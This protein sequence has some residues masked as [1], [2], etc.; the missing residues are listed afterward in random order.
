[1]QEFK[2]FSQANKRTSEPKLNIENKVPGSPSQPLA[3]LAMPKLL[4]QVLH[5]DSNEQLE[6]CLVSFP[7]Q[8]LFLP[9]CLPLIT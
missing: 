9:I 1:M 5:A 3:I 8:D 4:L 7:S 2:Q 6:A